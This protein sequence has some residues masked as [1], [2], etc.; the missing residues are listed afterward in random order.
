MSEKRICV[1]IDKLV[2][3]SRD[4]FG[5]QDGLTHIGSGS[6]GGKA[7]GLAF[8]RDIISTHF[9][10]QNYQG[11]AIDISRFTVI[12]TDLFD[13]FMKRNELYEIAYSDE[14]DDRIAH[15]FQNAELPAE[16]VG[17]LW[18]LIAA[19]HTPLAVRSASMLEDAMYEP[20]AGVYATKMIPNNQHDIDQ[21]FHKLVEA[22]K[23]V[24]ASI[25][26]K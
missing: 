22:I 24:Y 2:P 25:Y 14:P 23:F 10:E 5:S 18:A 19:V 1:S 17:D 4:F 12:A 15:A 26:F 21:R 20:F 13:R 11:V 7:S 3:F 9:E 16:L 8:I 6:I